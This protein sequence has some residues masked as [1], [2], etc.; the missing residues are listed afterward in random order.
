MESLIQVYLPLASLLIILA[1]VL[2]VKKSFINWL[3]MV[4][5]LAGLSKFLGESVVSD[6]ETVPS[7]VR[8]G[9]LSILILT[10]FIALSY[11]QF[12]RDKGD[13]WMYVALA[14]VYAIGAGVAF[15][16]K[17]NFTS[18]MTVFT[19]YKLLLSVA[20]NLLLV[21]IIY[22]KL[23]LLVKWFK[24]DTESIRPVFFHGAMLMVVAL[25][26][27]LGVFVTG[28]YGVA[29]FASLFL[30]TLIIL[31]DEDTEYLLQQGAFSVVGLLGLGYVISFGSGLEFY[32]GHSHLIFGAFIGGFILVIGKLMGL[33]NDKFKAF[34][35]IMV[36]VVIG[37]VYGLGY[38]YSI[39]ENLGGLIT[40]S[41]VLIGMLL[42]IFNSEKGKYSYSMGTG[43]ITLASILLFAP[44]F[45]VVDPFAEK[46]SNADKI[47]SDQ[48]KVETVNEK[49]EKVVLELNDITEAK[50][51]WEVFLDNSKLKFVVV[52]HGN[53]TKGTFK[54][55]SGTISIKEKL[56]D[57]E[58]TMKFDATSLSTFNKTRDGEIKEGEDWMHVS[59]F[60][61]LE[62]HAKGFKLEGDKYVT[63]G[64][65]TM[66][67][68]TKKVQVSFVFEGK[69]NNAGKDFIIV[70]GNLSLD[71][72]NFGIP[73]SS[74]VD[75]GVEIEF[76][77]E[78]NKLD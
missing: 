63:E 31:S 40:Y 27:Y 32:L 38:L 55:Y 14:V 20:L 53:T 73:E 46:G 21:A 65:L 43:L 41:G 4:L 23:P 48:K 17:G 58:V 74:E 71:M 1:N 15:G 39:K 33:M 76:T 52:S 37:M 8:N 60:P 11:R 61:E 77:V 28:W 59:K 19:G 29:F 2:F 25:S 30:P 7:I 47:A 13:K 67:G 5:I 75:K 78:A 35:I 12:F 24:I 54:N 34:K 57:C 51:N 62:F 9:V 68:I 50:G 45:E 44:F 56:E 6:G 72:T 66:K 10:T 42:M 36:A 16:I 64:D 69:G 18:G 70:S 49:G 22:L 3:P 26:V